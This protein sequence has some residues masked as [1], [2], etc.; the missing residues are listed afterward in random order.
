MKTKVSFVM[1]T[2]LIVLGYL[3]AA[4]D[5]AFGQN[6]TICRN[7]VCWAVP[8]VPV[9]PVAVVPVQPPTVYVPQVTYKPYQYQGTAVYRKNY[10]TPLRTLLFGR[11]RATHFYAPV[12]R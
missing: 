4:A 3:F 10:H 2:A 9:A 1:A 12:Q 8:V 7:G 11:Y 6:N 5:T